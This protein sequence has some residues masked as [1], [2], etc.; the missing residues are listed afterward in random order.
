MD[1]EGKGGV[2]W[3][4]CDGRVLMVK[5]RLEGEGIPAVRCRSLAKSVQVRDSMNGMR[6]ATVTA[7]ERERKC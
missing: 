1:G 2:R 5:W 4:R 6:T 3:D 7:R